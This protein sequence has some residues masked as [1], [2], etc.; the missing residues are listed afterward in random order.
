MARRLTTQ[1]N[2]DTHLC[3]AVLVI[4]QSKT[5]CD[6]DRA[7]TVFG[8]NWILVIEKWNF[9][10]SRYRWRNYTCRKISPSFVDRY[11][12]THTLVANQPRYGEGG[13]AI[14]HSASCPPPFLSS[15]SLLLW[16]SS[17]SQDILC[18]V[19]SSPPQGDN[20]VAIDENW[21]LGW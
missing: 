14:A 8:L 2:N 1:N 5:A 9:Y 4:Q 21:S 20:Y 7:A 11:K 15:L 13:G 12:Y 17:G 19:Y 16:R 3:P 6:L 18:Q 10:T